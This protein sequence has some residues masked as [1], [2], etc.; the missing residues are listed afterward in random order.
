M[1][2]GSSSTSGLR[3]RTQ[4][5]D[6]SADGLVLRGGEPNVLVVVNDLASILELLQ[7]VHRAVG[8]GIIDDDDFFIGVALR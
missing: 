1:K 2:L 7:Y 4:V 6:A 5:P 8:G 3:V